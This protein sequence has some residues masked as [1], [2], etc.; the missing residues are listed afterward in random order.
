MKLK[1]AWCERE[2]R[3]AALADVEP[4]ENHAET[5]G[6]CREHR[7]KWLQSLGLSEPARPGRSSSPPSPPA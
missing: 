6:L 1:C 3:P 7:R 2:G 5:H 4:L